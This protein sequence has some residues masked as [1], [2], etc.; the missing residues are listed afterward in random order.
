MDSTSE[1]DIS[2]DLIDLPEAPLLEMDI[3][4]DPIQK[5]SSNDDSEKEKF[6]IPYNL[7]EL[8]L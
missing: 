2:E 5:D 7:K 1:M 6:T 4:E 8:I 3:P